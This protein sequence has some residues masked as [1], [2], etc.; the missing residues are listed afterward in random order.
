MKS[1]RRWE[2]WLALAGLGVAVTDFGFFKLSGVEMT[3]GDRDATLAERLVREN[4]VYGGET[5]IREVLDAQK[6][7]PT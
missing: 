6:S 4:A 7:S 2:V 3:V 5:L 1:M